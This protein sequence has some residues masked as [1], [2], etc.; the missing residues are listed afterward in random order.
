[1]IRKI[2]IIFFIYVAITTIIY[3]FKNSD[4]S[5]TQLFLRIPYAITLQFDRR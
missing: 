3:R 2:L 4:L 1:M 5:E